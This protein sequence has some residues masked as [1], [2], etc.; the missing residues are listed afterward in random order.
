[1]N[2]WITF[3]VGAFFAATLAL[4]LHTIDVNHIEAKHKREL[5][6]QAAAISGDC[7]KAKATT[8]KVSHGLQN[9]L[10]TLD[11][12]YNALSDRLQPYPSCIGA[13]ALATGSPSG[14]D[15][16]AATGKSDEGISAA[17]APRRVIKI[18]K[19]GERYRVQ[20][21]ACQSWAREVKKAAVQNNSPH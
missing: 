21:I 12:D 3:G 5:V 17:F 13:T 19:K 10:S 18:V 15:G 16:A 4:A 7:A 20:L 11:N 14:H 6:A 2:F 9:D 8:E 1:M